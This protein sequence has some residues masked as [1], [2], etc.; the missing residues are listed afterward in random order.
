ML[1][2]YQR[3]ISLGDHPDG[4]KKAFGDEIH[5]FLHCHL[6]GYDRE[7]RGL[8]MHAGYYDKYGAPVKVED[9]WTEGYYT[10]EQTLSSHFNHCLNPYVG[11]PL[12][13]GYG[14]A[15]HLYDEFHGD[16][17]PWNWTGWIPKQR[18]WVGQLQKNMHHFNNRYFLALR[19]NEI[20]NNLWDYHPHE[21]EE[22]DNN[23]PYDW[24]YEQI[25][26][27]DK[28]RGGYFYEDHE[29]RAFARYLHIMALK[30]HYSVIIEDPNNADVRIV[31]ETP[32][33]KCDK[34]VSTAKEYRKKKKIKEP[35]MEI[36]K[37]YN[38]IVHPLAYRSSLNALPDASVDGIQWAIMNIHFEKNF[39]E[40][41]K[42]WGEKVHGMEI[43]NDFT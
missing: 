33:V 28:Y 6:R 19:G 43:F 5:L 12:V 30:N 35:T 42:N 20:Q 31:G 18:T 32:E 16:D 29:D 9:L 37:R 27:S 7:G 11:F 2:L 34:L 26:P 1:G 17:E 40:E 36:T 13:I 22:E 10:I 8:Q 15:A 24:I 14:G 21:D 23:N 39:T 3:S 38:Y 4:E 41:P 25:S